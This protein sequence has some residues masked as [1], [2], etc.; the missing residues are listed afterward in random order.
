MNQ[1]PEVKVT[2]FTL[3]KTDIFLI[4]ISIVWMIFATVAHEWPMLF[5]AIAYLCARIELCMM[6][7]ELAYVLGEIKS[8]E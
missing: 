2:A 4:V 3:N 1:K 8:D 7:G 6:K 5:M